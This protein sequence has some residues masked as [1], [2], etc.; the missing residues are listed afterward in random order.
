ML[1]SNSMKWL[2]ILH[3]IS[4]STWFGVTVSIGVLAVISFFS[5]GKTDFLI[6]SP[7]IPELYQK[8]ILPMTIITI[9]QGFIY[10]FLTNWGFF[11]YGWVLLKWILTLLLIPCVGVGTIG[12]MFLIIDKV[13]TSGFTGGL[14]DGGTVLIFIS[15]QILIMLIMITI[16][17]F[18]PK[19]QSHTT[20]LKSETAKLS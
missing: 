14:S 20:E 9:I 10:G 19:R 8:V 5:L 2:R 17:V 4:A 15:L 11:R 16:S 12:Q 18:K 13:N 7:L 6:I 1:K 3:I